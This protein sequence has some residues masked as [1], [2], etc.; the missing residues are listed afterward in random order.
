MMMEGVRSLLS[1]EGIRWFIGEFTSILASPLLVWLFLILIAIGCVRSSG[2]SL[3][4]RGY[5][6][7]VALRVALA[8]LII[9]VGILCLLTLMPHAIL[10]SATG[11]L[12]PSAFSRALVP[13]VCFGLC[14]VS[15][16]FGLIAGRLRSLA[17]I[18][19][20]LSTGLRDGA[21]LLIIYILFIQFYASLRFV[22]G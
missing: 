14:L 1:S 16:T 10:L 22:F 13:I 5:R 11:E 17:D 19:E 3:R 2:L 20:A 18:L 8:F 21:P 9:Y 12:F 6:D 4:V 7:Q 15:L